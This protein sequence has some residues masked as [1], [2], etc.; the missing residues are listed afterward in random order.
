MNCLSE[1]CLSSD[2][3]NDLNEDDERTFKSKKSI[4]LNESRIDFRENWFEMID[5]D[6]IND[7]L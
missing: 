3:L 6:N 5:E 2:F 4:S 1:T 7:E